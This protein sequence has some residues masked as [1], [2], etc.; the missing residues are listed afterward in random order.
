MAVGF[1][2]LLIA[3][4]AILAFAIDRDFFSGFN[5]NIAGYVLIGVGILGLIVSLVTNAQRSRTQHTVVDERRQP[6]PPPAQY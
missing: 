5:L 3:V 2:I 4:G 6:P 1:S